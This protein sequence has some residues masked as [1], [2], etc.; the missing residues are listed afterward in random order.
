MIYRPDTSRGIDFYVD[1]D[2]SGGWKDGDHNSPG[3]VLSH[4]GF[5]IMYDGCPIHWKKKCVQKFTS[6]LRKA[7]TL[8]CQ[9]QREN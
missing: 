3:S 7:S 2:F 1:G 4:T 9:P 5:V 8:I 6:V